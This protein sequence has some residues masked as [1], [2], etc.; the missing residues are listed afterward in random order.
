MADSPGAV[1]TLILTFQAA[2]LK[3]NIEDIM[4]FSQ[5][6]CFS[7]LMNVHIVKEEKLSVET[8]IFFLPCFMTSQLQ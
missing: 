3:G 6:A 8:M 1:S 2:A 7:K 4:A 5:S